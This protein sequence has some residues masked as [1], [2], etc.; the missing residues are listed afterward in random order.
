MCYAFSVNGNVTTGG[1]VYVAI[2]G[3]VRGVLLRSTNAVPNVKIRGNTHAG[4][5]VTDQ[6]IFRGRDSRS[7]LSSVG[8][9]CKALSPIVQRQLPSGIGPLKALATNTWCEVTYDG[10][11]YFLGAHGAL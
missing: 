2:S 11:A 8:K 3:A 1:A 6:F 4:M 5:G 7:S 9:R 10:S